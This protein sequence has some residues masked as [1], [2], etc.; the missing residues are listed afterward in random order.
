MAQK[1]IKGNA[2]TSLLQWN[3]KNK[4]MNQRFLKIH[5]G[6]KEL[7]EFLNQP[8]KGKKKTS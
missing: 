6:L 1:L 8:K 5:N 3:Y 2:R 4:K 7:D